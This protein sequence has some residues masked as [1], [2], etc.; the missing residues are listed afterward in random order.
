M[1]NIYALNSYVNRY[2]PRSLQTKLVVVCVPE[3]QRPQPSLRPHCPDP[4]AWPALTQRARHPSGNVPRFPPFSWDGPGA[5]RSVTWDTQ[6]PQQGHEPEQ[7]H[8]HLP[9]HAAHGDCKQ[10]LNLVGTFAQLH[11]FL[12]SFRGKQPSSSVCLSSATLLL[13]D[14]TSFIQPFSPGFGKGIE[15]FEII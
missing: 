1:R 8:R 11:Y 3:T 4:P 9:L 6:S 5:R 12:S 10:L 2:I 14:S 7:E 15:F 13:P